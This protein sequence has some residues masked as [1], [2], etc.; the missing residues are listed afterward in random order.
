MSSMRGCIGHED[1]WPWPRLSKSFSHDFAIKLLKY[2]TSCHVCSTA[3]TFLNGF[4]PYLAQIFTSIR[5][6]VMCNDLWPWP[7]SSRSFSHH[8]TIELLKYGTSCQVCSTAYTVRDGFFPYLAQIITSM[9]GCVAC[10]DLWPWPISSRLFSCDFAYFMDC[11]YEWH[12]YNPSGDDVSHTIC[13]SKVKVTQVLLVFA[14]GAGG[15]LVD[16]WSIVSSSIII[17][18]LL[19]LLTLQPLRALGYC[20]TPSGRVGGRQGRQA[21]LRL[22]RP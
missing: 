16:L 10:N 3:W 5:W 8:L 1:F 14:V 2:V 13:R 17:S 9:R 18:A 15:I 6:C 19:M 20:R 11:I 7:I 12:K 4:F 22:S 21:P